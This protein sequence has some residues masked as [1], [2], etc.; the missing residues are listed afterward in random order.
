MSQQQQQRQKEEEKIIDILSTVFVLLYH[1]NT[2]FRFNLRLKEKTY[3][4][5][6]VGDNGETNPADDFIVAGT[7]DRTRQSN[8][9][10]NHALPRDTILHFFGPQ[11]RGEQHVM[12]NLFP[13]SSQQE[14]AVSQ[15]ALYAPNSSFF[16]ITKYHDVRD[17]IISQSYCSDIVS[18]TNEA[19]TQF[20]ILRMLYL[21]IL[22]IGID[23]RVGLSLKPLRLPSNR[24]WF[25]RN[26]MNEADSIDV[27]T[28]RPSHTVSPPPWYQMLVRFLDFISPVKS[29]RLFIPS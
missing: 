28:D 21:Y 20:Y 23:N 14:T 9:F 4:Y 12:R 3:L 11:Q 6:G 7:R 18:L 19:T 16:K 15:D 8:T 1:P 22:R 25:K 13:P 26:I 5:I 17:T 10:S 29:E 27:Q 2:K 24:E